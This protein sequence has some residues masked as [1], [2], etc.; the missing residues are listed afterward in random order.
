M[1]NRNWM[2]VAVAMMVG[3]TVVLVQTDAAARTA[4]AVVS[5]MAR[6]G[7]GVASAE[8]QAEATSPAGRSAVDYRWTGR[9]DA[10]ASLEIKGLN[11]SIDAVA[12]RGDEVVVTAEARARRS[13]PA[14]VR[15]ERVEHADGITFCA[16]YP[17]PEGREPNTCAPGSAGRMNNQRNDVQVD[18]RVAV[19][20]GVTFVGRT[21]N[22]GVEAVG[23]RSDVR[24]FTVN[25][26]VEV[27]TTGFAE[28]ET[29]NGSIEA[30]MGSTELRDGVEF[31]TVNGSIVLDLP[32]GIDAELDASWLNGSFESD[33]PFLLQG[34]LSKRSA[35]GVLGDGGPRLELETVNGSIRIR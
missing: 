17:T 22:G 2:A 35:R 4:E 14:S 25:G 24:A 29:V 9:M 5:F 21:V 20:E 34:S 23:L 30:S 6:M 27:S 15:I 32:D 11:G 3:G 10:G 18:F 13:D 19:P 16:V 8:N 26:D 28:A 7:M 1:K 12:A 31:S 33:I